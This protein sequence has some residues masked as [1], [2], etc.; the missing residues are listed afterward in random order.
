VAFDALVATYYAPLCEFVYLFLRSH[1]AAEDLVQELF[2]TLWERGEPRGTRDLRPYLYRAARNRA[3][4]VLRHRRIEDRW[5]T[6][7]QLTPT[8]MSAPANA[9][10]EYDDLAQAVARAVDALPERCRLIFR[11]SRD[12]GLTYPMIAHALGLSVKTVETQMVRAIRAIRAN[13]APY[14]V[15]GF[16]LIERVLQR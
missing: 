13:V 14:L 2:I 6:D 10:V 8:A 12:Q 4:S 3:I 7:V 1:A 16:T 5:Q 15:I 9:A 11:M